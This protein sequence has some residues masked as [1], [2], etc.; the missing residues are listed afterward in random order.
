M[1][2]VLILIFSA[3]LFTQSKVFAQ[4]ESGGGDFSAESDYKPESY[5]SGFPSAQDEMY[6][7]DRVRFENSQK[8]ENGENQDGS[9]EGADGETPGTDT[10]AEDDAAKEKAEEEEEARKENERKLEEQRR[11]EEERQRQEK[12]QNLTE[13]ITEGEAEIDRLDKELNALLKNSSSIISA[14]DEE[15][16]KKLSRIEEKY[17][18]DVVPGNG[19]IYWLNHFY[20]PSNQN[21]LE[22]EKE[23]EISLVKNQAEVD[24]L[25]LN[26]KIEGLQQQLSAKKT[27]V[28]EKK[29]ELEETEKAV[30][31]GDPV[32]LS[33]GEF[34][35]AER[36]L[37]LPFGPSTFDI[38]RSLYSGQKISG[39]ILG[40]GWTSSLECRIIRGIDWYD[41]G[42]L[43]NL[44]DQCNQ[45]TEEIRDLKDFLALQINKKTEIEKQIDACNKLKAKVVEV[46]RKLKQ[47]A[48]ELYRLDNRRIDY[49]DD[50]SKEIDS[51]LE[52]LENEKISQEYIDYLSEAITIS[53]NLLKEK[54]KIR[55]EYAATVTRSKSIDQYNTYVSYGF[56]DSSSENSF[57]Y[58]GSGTLTLITP[59]G[60]AVSF[61]FDGQKWEC[62]TESAKKDYTLSTSGN[63]DPAKAEGFTVSKRDGSV[64]IFDRYGLPVSFADRHENVLNFSHDFTKC[65]Q[66]RTTSIVLD[67]G[68]SV[69]LAYDSQGKLIEIG[70][71]R[72]E[73]ISFS[74]TGQKLVSVTDT[75]GDKISFEYRNTVNN[76]GSGN[77]ISSITKA[78]GSK[79]RITYGEESDG[80]LHATSTESENGH[81][82]SFDYYP[83]EHKVVYTDYSGRK[84][85]TYYDASG[86]LEKEIDNGGQITN[87]IYDSRGNMKNRTDSAGTTTYGYDSFDQCTSVRFP[88]GSTEHYVYD[89][90]GLITAETDRNGITTKFMRDSRGNI[91][92]VYVADKLREAYTWSD[93][94]YLLSKT[95]CDGITT[96]YLRDTRGNLLKR[97][98]ALSDAANHVFFSGL[99]KLPADYALSETVLQPD[100]PITEEW[101][102]DSLDR[103]TT[104]TDGSGGKTFYSYG[105]KTETIVTPSKLQQKITYNCRKDP[106]SIEETD[107]MTGETRTTLYTYDLQHQLVKSVQVESGLETE[108]SYDPEGNLCHASMGKNGDK[109]EYFYTYDEL[110]RKKSVTLSRT[111][112][113]GEK[114]GPFTQYYDYKKLTGGVWEI[115]VRDDS[116]II[117]TVQCT[118]DNLPLLSSSGNQNV[119]YKYNPKDQVSEITNVQGGKTYYNYDS[120][121]NIR[122]VSED[123][124]AVWLYESSPSGKII[125]ETDPE[126]NVTEY[127]YNQLG[128]ISSV[129]T[130][131]SICFYAYDFSGKCILSSVGNPDISKAESFSAVKFFPREI[132][133]TGG[134]IS[135]ARYILNAWGEIVSSVDGNGNAS[136]Y[137]RDSSGNLVSETDPYSNTTR[138][139]RNE[140]GKVYRIEYSDGILSDM[141]YDA[142]GNLI[143]TTT[144]GVVEF[145]ACYDQRGRCISER[146]TPGSLKSFAYDDS[147]RIT[148]YFSAGENTAHLQYAQDSL[149]YSLVNS[150]GDSYTFFYDSYGNLIS[151]KDRTG[152]LKYYE[153]GKS[154]KLTATKDFDGK[155]TTYTWIPESRTRITRYYDD[156]TKKL[157]YDQTGNLVSFENLAGK[158]EFAYNQAGLIQEQH[159]VKSGDK[160]YSFY[161][162]AGNRVRLTGSGTDIWYEYGK[163]GELLSLTDCFQNMGTSFKYDSRGRE[164]E[165]A[166]SDGTR[167]F[168]VYYP[169]GQ[170]LATWMTDDKGLILWGEGY[171]YDDFGRIVHSVTDEGLITSYRYDEHGRLSESIYPYSEELDE[172]FRNEAEQCGLFTDSSTAGYSSVTSNRNRN[173]QEKEILS[174]T[175]VYDSWEVEKI[176]AILKIF[177]KKLTN[178]SL[179]TCNILRECYT[180]DRESNRTGKSTKYGEI[181]YH[182]DA[183]NRLI[184]FGPSGQNRTGVFCTYDARGNLIAE[185]GLISKSYFEY[186]PENR[187]VCSSVTNLKTNEKSSTHYSYDA[188]GRRTLVQDEKGPLMRT[189]Y[190]GLGFDRIK[191]SPAY[192]N[193]TALTEV[194]SWRNLS[195]ASNEYYHDSGLSFADKDSE[196]TEQN[197][198]RVSQQDDSF[199]PGESRYQFIADNGPYSA[200]SKAET[201]S[202]TFQMSESAGL[203]ENAAKRY[204]GLRFFLCA[205]GSEIGMQFSGG[206]SEAKDLF[207]GK[208]FFAH[209]IKGSVRAVSGGTPAAG[210]TQSYTVFGTPTNS[211]LISAGVDSGYTGKPFD[212]ATGFYD[213]GFRDF[214][215]ANAR[216]TTIDP[217]RDGFNWYA[218]SANDPVNFLDPFGLNDNPIDDAYRMQNAKWKTN[219]L[220]NDPKNKT[221][222]EAGCAVTK[223]ADLSH[224]VGGYLTPA[225]VNLLY[226]ENG[227]VNWEAF[228]ADANMTAKKESFNDFLKHHDSFESDDK[229]HYYILQC[230]TGYGS[231]ETKNKGDHFVGATG[232]KVIDDIEYLTISPSSDNDDFGQTNYRN[233]VGWEK[234]DG[235]ILVPFSAL[236]QVV[237]FTK[238]NK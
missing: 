165:R 175:T 63:P 191:E 196:Q 121:G 164:T 226:V 13:D 148:D 214:A 182:Y 154:G 151:E 127:S 106:V 53:E 68:I 190:D 1:L 79:I 180:Y 61:A 147:N 122:S 43:G 85:T 44:N 119:S 158:T 197:L 222:G 156:S 3:G 50:T 153:Y 229:D 209:D 223:V 117:R 86:R 92:S 38:T 123:S 161:D 183:E 77:E 210:K 58:S 221:I 233:D 184:F 163:N 225:Q 103:A 211:L 186:D 17:S 95:D 19:S 140:Q 49:K 102:Y 138:F 113:A 174:E 42:F 32:M 126:G 70:T 152:K 90:Y 26:N 202:D 238:N 107:L 99:Q 139:Y 160:L 37:S 228:A 8:K 206:A 104:H 81:I 193:G 6:G 219:I 178:N 177:Q 168:T 128:E 11:A 98:T 150:A 41:E 101:T 187:M 112:S 167:Q 29:T 48:D 232:Y 94:G 67:N 57:K 189:L 59:K 185:E 72:G 28:A 124:G 64:Y 203:P 10:N 80:V 136:F 120:S 93:K 75:D 227:N 5:Y 33:T 39:G 87:Y 205:N 108:Y 66:G 100:A 56:A 15:T 131:E 110:N 52:K 201:R 55:N 62:K 20:D 16:K 54:E 170:T 149:S 24:K 195:A 9:T 198:I 35:Y 188:L 89:S 22:T 115:T 224:T 207:K 12:A 173:L 76:S 230:D 78:D 60:N 231:E 179:Y 4:E 46:E 162:N 235:E 212:L 133:L 111:D 192:E 82:E 91:T 71:N 118:H 145:E 47:D 199:M 141:K 216:F 129:R 218:Y 18:G 83:S 65:P 134:G 137:E 217:I 208:A 14:I 30:Y 142:M 166:F 213:Y 74:Y 21:I 200:V 40:Q 135:F 97:T 215:P 36:D 176:N 125:R 157:I 73:K 105:N 27:E 171:V 234:V 132:L 88:D 114:S 7:A 144:A 31:K 69:S 143:K 155:E 25:N 172:I 84:S 146:K 116:G 159:D 109:T 204:D 96:C 2:A 169:W 236:H 34:F 237:V 51:I 23:R 194:F 181:E 45:L 220:K 130:P